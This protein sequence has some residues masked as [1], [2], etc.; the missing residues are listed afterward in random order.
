MGFFWDIRELFGIKVF[1]IIQ[2]EITS[3]CNAKCKMCPKTHLRDWKSGDMH[4]ETFSSISSFFRMANYIHL[5]GWGE[6]LLHPEL[7]TMIK[8]IKK[9]PSRCGFTTNGHLLFKERINRFIDMEVNII[10]ISLAGTNKA[11]HEAV[12]AGTDFTK[13]MENVEYLSNERKKRSLRFPELV[14][15]LIMTSQNMHQLPDFVRMGAELGADR[16]VANNVDLVPCQE[17][18]KFR[19]FGFEDEGEKYKD[20]VAEA[21]ELAKEK[22]VDFRIYPISPEEK[23]VC[24]ADPINNVYIAFDGCVSPCVYLGLPV[25]E[26]PI[27]RHDS[28]WSI[29]RRCFGNVNEES[30]I[31]IW[32]KEEYLTFRDMFR[33]RKKMFTIDII[34]SAFLGAKPKSNFPVP[35]ECKECYK[36][37]GF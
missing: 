28:F 22:G 27:Y 16:V 33:K 21:K 34:I 35:N 4:M 20:F 2:I 18:D 3:R 11:I 7:E 32:K 17:I 19:V 30:L 37:F 8:M 14:L 24:E 10:A 23:G 36:L 6:P 1:D 9:A 29:P 15:L 31:D 25:M 5:Q 26:I 13:I 12:R